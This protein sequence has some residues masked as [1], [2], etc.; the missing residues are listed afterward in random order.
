MWTT[1]AKI[2]NELNWR[3]YQSREGHHDASL[4]DVVGGD[5]HRAGQLQV[6]Q[7]QVV[8]NLRKHFLDL[9][10]L[11]GVEHYVTQQLPPF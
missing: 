4:Q 7:H 6:L 1:M 2:P 10:G 5:L 8:G 3:T 9:M 11:W